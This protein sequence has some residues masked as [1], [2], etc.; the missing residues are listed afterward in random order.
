MAF[1]MHSK[2]DYH[3][4]ISLKAHLSLDEFLLDV[5]NIEAASRVY[6]YFEVSWFA[7]GLCLKNMPDRLLHGR[8]EL[9]SIIKGGGVQNFSH[10][11]TEMLNL[12]ITCA[13]GISKR[14]GRSKMHA[15]Q[16]LLADKIDAAL[17]DDQ[18]IKNT[19]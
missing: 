17:C 6:Y 8:E 19:D 11:L 16:K 14:V 1:A 13:D 3:D 7:A 18:K 10:N 5:R 4:F 2:F 15:A 12:A 9:A